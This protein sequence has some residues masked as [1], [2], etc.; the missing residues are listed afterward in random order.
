MVVAL[1]LL[2]TGSLRAQ[3]P[4]EA[5]DQGR[6]LTAQ[7]LDQ[8]PAENYAATGTLKI[9]DGNGTRTELPAQFQTIITPTNWASV[10]QVGDTARVYRLT[11]LHADGKPDEYFSSTNPAVPL[12]GS[13]PAISSRDARLSGQETMAP[14][15]GSDFWIADL[16]LEFLHW[17]EQKVLKK[18]VKRSRG[19][20]VLESTNPHPA[21]GGYG[22]VVSWIDSETGG[23]VQAEAYDTNGKELKEFYPKDFKKVDGQWR[24]GMMEMDN[25]Q[26][27][28]RSRLEFDLNS[29]TSTPSQ[30]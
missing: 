23:I 17:P 29:E 7:L 11:I 28:S 22:R 18:E 2:A 6:A 5:G 20:T 24:V 3:S 19:C 1:F 14:F 13:L 10:Y 9:R 12:H 4:S 16:G 26:T 30:K 21:A 15:A 25:D 8:H 27:S